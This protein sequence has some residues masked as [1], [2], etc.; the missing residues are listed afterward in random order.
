MA[1]S[2]GSIVVT[3]AK[4][5]DEALA[6]AKTLE[7]EA[8]SLRSSNT[9]RSAQL[10]TGKEYT[11]VTGHMRCRSGVEDPGALSALK[12]HLVEG[13]NESS[14]IL[15]TRDGWRGERRVRLRERCHGRTPQQRRLTLWRTIVN[16]FMQNQG[17][18]GCTPVLERPPDAEES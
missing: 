17:P 10:H 14:L 3:A 18:V 12:C 2:G 5:R 9:E 8:A 6:T 11:I 1:P 4:L 7:D 13:G 16:E 15:A